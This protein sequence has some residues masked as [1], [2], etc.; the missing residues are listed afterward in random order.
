MYSCVQQY[1]KSQFVKLSNL[2]S[3]HETT[4]EPL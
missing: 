1:V 3:E 4:K 2:S